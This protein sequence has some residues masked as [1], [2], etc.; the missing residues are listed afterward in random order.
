MHNITK[1][2][3]FRIL[4]RITYLPA[5]IFL[6]PL[7]HLR[8]KSRSRLFFFFDRYSL[9]GAQRIHLDILDSVPEAEKEIF[10]TRRSPNTVFRNEFYSVPHSEHRDIHIYCDYLLLRLFSVHYYSFYI[11]RHRPARIFGANSTFFYDMLPFISEK[12]SRTELLHNFT[13]G[14][15]GMEFFGLLNYRL[16][17]ERVI[18][19]FYTK[20]N[21]EKQYSASHIDPV[22]LKRLL[23]IEPGVHIPPEKIKSFER[24]L[25]IICAGRGGPQKR[26]WLIN[27]IAEY[28]IEKKM[29]VVFHF[30]GTL[31][32]ELSEIV[33]T[34]AVVHGEIADPEK[35]ATLLEQSDIALLVSLYE[36]FPMFIKEAMAQSCI[37]LVTALPGNRMHLKEGLNCLLI[38]AIENEDEVVNQAV[39]KIFELLDHPGLCEQLSRGAYTYASAHFSR[40]EFNK[41]YRAL[42]LKPEA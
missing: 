42:L 9:G 24:P 29:P 6:Y 12:I 27:R 11:N 40:I 34:R 19:D 39:K 32:A 5:L 36:G 41:R 20:E 37:P 18:Y 28:F 2:K 31:I 8:K 26:I 35:M 3:L 14:K 15:N 22:Y 30:A 16:L 38:E 23:F 17:T 25:K 33:K 7:A 21:I 1:I 4:L 10:F 13:F